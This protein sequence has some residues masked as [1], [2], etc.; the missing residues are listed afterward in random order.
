MLI[1]AIVMGKTD[2]ATLGL[3]LTELMEVLRNLKRLPAKTLTITSPVLWQ[4]SS[5]GA[6][7]QPE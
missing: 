6:C 1:E 2:P 3:R 7:V 4:G 5:A